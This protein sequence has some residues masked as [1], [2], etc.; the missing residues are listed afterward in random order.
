MNSVEITRNKIET[1]YA[2][3]SQLNE[4]KSEG[5]KPKQTCRSAAEIDADMAAV[6]HEWRR[7]CSARICGCM[8]CAN[9]GLHHAGHQSISQEEYDIWAAAYPEKVPQRNWSAAKQ[10]EFAKV[11]SR[12]EKD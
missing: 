8:G 3:P 11:L 2:V 7:M 5:L 6:P 12:Y 9:A 4:T 1:A 10:A